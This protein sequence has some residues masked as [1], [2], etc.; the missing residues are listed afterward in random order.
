M[1]PGTI[2]QQNMKIQVNTLTGKRYS[3]E[4]ESVHEIREKVAREMA[5]SAVILVH[6]GKKLRDTINIGQLLQRDPSL[7]DSKSILPRL[8]ISSAGWRIDSRMVDIMTSVNDVFLNEDDAEVY[9]H[10]DLGG[11]EKPHEFK[12]E[13]TLRLPILVMG[14]VV[15]LQVSELVRLDE[16]EGYLRLSVDKSIT[17][18]IR[19]EESYLSAVNNP[20]TE[21]VKGIRKRIYRPLLERRASM[22]D[23]S[24]K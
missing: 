11:P 22:R 24:Q 15:T 4:A 16:L 9:A 17:P 8:M 18:I 19:K 2:S 12:K 6:Q 20:A 5:T 7:A 23:K 21:K 10:M 14:T 1:V 3:I 13:K